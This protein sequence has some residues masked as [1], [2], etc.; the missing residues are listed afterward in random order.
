M[1]RPVLLALLL[2]ISDDQAARTQAAAEGMDET[3]LRVA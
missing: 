2:R 3:Q 1:L